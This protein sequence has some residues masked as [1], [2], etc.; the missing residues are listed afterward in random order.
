LLYIICSTGAKGST[1]T[2][3]KI[4]VRVQKKGA[5]ETEENPGLAYRTIRCATGQC[6]MHHRTVSGALGRIDLKLFTF[7]FL[8]AHS[9]I[10]HRT[11]RCTKQ[12]NGYPRN[13][14]LHSALIEL[15]FAAE[16][17]AGAGGAPDSEQCLS[18]APSCQSSN[19]RNC[20]NP[21]GW[22]M[23]LAHRILS[24]GAPDCSVRPSTAALPNDCFGG[25]GYKYPPTT[26]IQGIQVSSHLHS[27][28]EL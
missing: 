28:Q 11:V 4:R 9:A 17:R 16:V 10:I 22:V 6:P 20:Q 23:W 12:S 25:W 1:Q 3:K 5:K 26:T 24:S 8:Q 27:I 18:G 7:G 19:G 14:R 15:Q 21:N 13:G 2:N